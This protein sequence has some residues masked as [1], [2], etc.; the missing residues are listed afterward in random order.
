MSGR[1]LVKKRGAG[2]SAPETSQER[3][4]NRRKARKRTGLTNYWMGLSDQCHLGYRCP[5]EPPSER[6]TGERERERHALQSTALVNW[7]I[8][9]VCLPL[10]SF[11]LS[12]RR[13]PFHFSLLYF[14]FFS[15]LNRRHLY[16]LCERG[17]CA[18]P[19]L[20]SFVDTDVS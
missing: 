13:R 10:F 15:L 18:V 5:T 4:V 3:A 2:A 8:S 20:R 6:N 1:L 11:S 17:T 19:T 7:R 9:P 16:I 14:L 12:C